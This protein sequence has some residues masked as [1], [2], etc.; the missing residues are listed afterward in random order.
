M[1]DTLYI[2]GNEFDLHYGLKTSY[3][4]FRD[5]FVKKSPKWWNLLYD[6]YEDIITK[7]MCWSNFEE[8]FGCIDYLNIIKYCNGEDLGFMKVLELLNRAFFPI[9]GKW[10]KDMN[11][12]V[13]IDNSLC[14]NLIAFFFTFNYSLLLEQFY[15]VKDKNIWHIHDSIKNV[16]SILVNHDSDERKLFAAY[17][18]YKEGKESF[19]I[20]VADN[21]RKEAIKGAKNVNNR[22]YFHKENFYLLYSNIKHHILKGF[23]SIILTFNI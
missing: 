6:V 12:L 15:H 3:S 13:Q 14:I 22:I 16:D 5:H 9:F 19:R 7:D 10:I 20:D 2:I 23:P 21:I 8:M 18:K 11:F 1:T 17:L 4:D